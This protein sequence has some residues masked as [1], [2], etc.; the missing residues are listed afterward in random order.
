MSRYSFISNY[1]SFG[2]PS[3]A[4]YSLLVPGLGKMLT[5]RGRKGWGTLISVVTLGAAAYYMNS[6]A[7]ASYEKYKD[8]VDQVEIDKFHAEASKLKTFALTASI[9]GASIWCLD[10]S[11]VYSIGKAN[12]NNERDFKNKNGLFK[13]GLMLYSYN[14][15]LVPSV[16]L[17]Y[18]FR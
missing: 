6:S 1:K 12:R 11:S 15:Y 5:S 8:A 16:G 3:N 14:N 4:M 18:C 13:S 10:I 9:L 17:K 7:N 2:G